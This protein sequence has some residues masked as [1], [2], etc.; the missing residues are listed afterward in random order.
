MNEINSGKFYHRISQNWFQIPNFTT[1]L[2]IY[3]QHSI[4]DTIQV[5]RVKYNIV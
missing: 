4:L 5:L 3:T 2:Y 1:Y